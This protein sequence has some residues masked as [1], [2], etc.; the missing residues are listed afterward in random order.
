MDLISNTSV[1][2]GDTSS[3]RAANSTEAQ[4]LQ[5]QRLRSFFEDEE[6]PNPLPRT[7]TSV[8]QHKKNMSKKIND[9][10]SKAKK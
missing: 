7:T 8:K 10:M 9:I 6:S 5:D 3:S 2:N 1:V 4:R